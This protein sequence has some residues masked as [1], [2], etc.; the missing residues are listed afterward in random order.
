MGVSMAYG[1]AAET[2]K[3]ALPRADKAH[4]VVR[5]LTPSSRPAFG[6]P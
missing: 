1:V 6:H 3:I 2:E 4:H 5:F